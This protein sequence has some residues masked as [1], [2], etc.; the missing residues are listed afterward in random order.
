MA[1]AYALALAATWVA[2]RLQLQPTSFLVAGSAAVVVA[3]TVAL[4]PTEGIGVFVLVSLLAETWQYVLRADLR[5]FDEISLLLLTG[6]IAVRYRRAIRIPRVG[7]AEYAV[8]ALVLVGVVSSVVNAVPPRIWI[9]GLLLL[10]K[11]VVFFYLVMWVHP[12]REE[13]QRVGTVIIGAA[14]LILLLGFIELVDRSAFQQAIGLPAYEQARAGLPVIKSVFLHPAVFGWLAVFASLFLYVRFLLLQSWWALPLAVAFDVGALL[15]GRRTPVLELV[16]ALVVAV[17][18]FWRRPSPDRSLARTWAPM[19]AGLILLGGLF[20]PAVGG[21]YGDTVNQY[22]SSPRALAEIL[23]KHPN[24]KLIAGVEPRTAL[25]VASIAI[26]RDH[27]P[28]GAGLGRFGSYM[29]RVEYSPLYQH[30]GLNRVYGLR[31]DLR[32]A[33]NDTF[34][35]SVLGETGPIGVLAFGAFLA[36]LFV[37]LWRSTRREPSRAWLVISLGALLVL[38]QGIVAS[39]TAAT[40]VAPPIAF[41]VFGT[42]AAVLGASESETIAQPGMAAVRDCRA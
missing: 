8:A 11:G 32:V 2:A 16:V 10:T 27:I 7:V 24:A 36:T 35:P 21:F 6:I 41:M 33:I 4:W 38:V 13:V 18:W 1:A 39:L 17:I 22:I 25:Y 5:Y 15:S 37:R 34:W 29:S 40:F 14:A 12:T 3:I 23:A 20:L 26:A 30:Y 28:L 9:P 42:V 19:L 31:P